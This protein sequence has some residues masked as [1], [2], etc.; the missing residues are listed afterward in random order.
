L[1]AANLNFCAA[2]SRRNPTLHRDDKPPKPQRWTHGALLPVR[3]VLRDFAASLPPPGT[4]ANADTLWRFIVGQ[5][6][7]ASCG[8]TPT[9]CSANCSA[10]AG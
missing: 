2:R 6:A 10:A 8:A 3:V 5:L 9:T 7:R 4:P 1:P